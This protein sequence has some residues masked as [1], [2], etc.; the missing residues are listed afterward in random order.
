MEG[1][2]LRNSFLSVIGKFYPSYLN[3]L[4]SNGF[5]EHHQMD[6]EASAWLSKKEPQLTNNVCY[7]CCKG[8]WWC[9]FHLESPDLVQ[10]FCFTINK[11][12]TLRGEERIK[13]TQKVN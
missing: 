5:Q 2:R 1:Q 3:L 12:N 4:I 13:A 10:S 8:E 9:M 11:T 6:S 7:K